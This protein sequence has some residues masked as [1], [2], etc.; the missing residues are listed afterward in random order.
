MDDDFNF[1]A[2]VW[3]SG[4]SEEPEPL[5]GPS[6]KSNIS[7]F[8]SFET[9][10]AFVDTDDV[11]DF[12]FGSHI[13]SSASIPEDDDFGD[14]GDFGDAVEGDSFAQ[15]TVLLD[16]HSFSTSTQDW[17]ALRLNP[18]PS[19]SSLRKGIGDL[20]D[21]IWDTSDALQ[22]LRDEN[23]RQVGGLNQILVTPERYVRYITR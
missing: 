15:E 21:S 10:D 14:F 16:D 23:I 17:T 7:T 6:S 12:E 9:E 19:T 20:L 4:A 13:Q 8:S 1:G 2:S 22:Y 18:L 3:A 5:A 11:G